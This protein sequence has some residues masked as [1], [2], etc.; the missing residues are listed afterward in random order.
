MDLLQLKYFC[1]AAKTQNFSKTASEFYVPVSN[2]SQCIKRLEGE[3]GVELFDHKKNTVA[4]NANGKI[5]YEYVS[6]ALETLNNGIKHVSDDEKNFSGDI[7]MVG[8]INSGLIN[9]VIEKFLLKYPSVKFLVSENVE[10]DPNF[11]LLISASP[12]ADY[13]EK[14]FLL[15]DKLCVAMSKSYPLAE[16]DNLSVYDLKNERFICSS[17]MSGLKNVITHACEEAGFSPN[18]AIETTDSNYLRKHVEKGFGVSFAPASWQYV[19][20][21]KMVFKPIENLYRQTFIYTPKNKYI[22]NRVRAFIEELKESAKTYPYL[23]DDNNEE[24]L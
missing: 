7:R 1:S 14:I 23:F 9:R 2:I 24:K 3:L 18:F 10:S 8:S 15:E 4:L 12:Y 21:E 6:N 19:Y 20:G 13:N 16:K 11:D 5:F 22:P 17:R